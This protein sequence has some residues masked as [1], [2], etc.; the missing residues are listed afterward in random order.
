MGDFHD[1]KTLYDH[2]ERNAT[3]HRSLR[4]IGE[5]FRELRDLKHEEKN[6]EESEKAQ[7]EVDFFNFSIT[8]GEI[9]PV[10]TRTNE[11]GE[12][13]E[14]PSLKRFDNRAYEYLMERLKKTSNPRLR[15]RY[16]HILWYSPHKHAK[17][18]K[19]AVGSYL[20][21]V[22]IYEK[23][24]EEEPQKHYGLDVI[25]AMKNA[26]AIACVIKHKLEEAKSEIIRLIR[27]F[28]FD[29][30]FSFVLRANLT[31]LVLM[32][33]KKF[34]PQDFIGLEATCWK[35]SKT[36]KE[37]NI[38]GAIT[39]LELGEKVDQKLGKK[40]QKWRRRIAEYYETLAN[41]GDLV[42]ITF[43]QL[44]LEN[45]RRIKDKRKVKELENKYSKLKDSIQLKEIKTEI[46]MTKQLRESRKIAHRVVQNDPV[47]IVEFLM[48]EKRLLPQYKAVE[49]FAEELG[50]QHVL[51]RLISKEIID[52]SGHPAE[53]FSSEDERKYYGILHQYNLDLRYVRIP[54]INEIFFAAIHKNKMSTRVL[55]EF[56]KEHS[57]F[58]K[59]I[60]K[61]LSN[62]KIIQYNWLSLIAPALNEYFIQMQYYFQ[63]PANL[64]NLVICID[65]LTLKI[66]GLLRDICRFAGVTTFRPTKDR[67]GRNIVR[68]KDIDALLH[69]EPV[70]KLFDEDDLLFFRFLLVE[71]AGFNLRNR[72]AHSL[73]LFQEYGINYMHLLIMALLRLGKYDFVK[74]ETSMD[75]Q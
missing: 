53:H 45:Y 11:K 19:I 42:S 23:K 12:V 31:E 1:L 15:A 38:H 62:N 73:M 39:M 17:Y 40:T 41:R 35:M 26:F 47:E 16:S 56:F 5:L 6:P 59:N 27:N 49:K 68:E 8:D 30:R 2:L 44:A 63:N 25:E 57:W 70:K 7:W 36:L 22:K 55:L 48:H 60:P 75:N 52:E 61:K 13:V 46:D 20:N 28:N 51:Q 33:K 34:S 43:C 18:A 74:K 4:H 10:Y 66:E 72:I 67:K 37:S 65:S 54:M 9:N 24:D 21:L 71:K 3:D 58:G 32:H 14:Y 29:S 50:K 64:P 69:E